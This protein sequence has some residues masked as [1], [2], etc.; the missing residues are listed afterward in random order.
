M[1]F[2]ILT[3]VL[4]ISTVRVLGNIKSFLT[5][6]GEF[7]GLSFLRLGT[8]DPTKCQQAPKHYEELGCKPI[9]KEGECCPQR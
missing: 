7:N 8:C 4:A 2:K 6:F 3:I 5:N 1:M 9:I